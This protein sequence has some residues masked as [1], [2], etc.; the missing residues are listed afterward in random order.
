[1]LKWR[2]SLSVGEDVDF[3]WCI[4]VLLSL[5]A[6]RTLDH[7]TID[8]NAINDNNDSNGTKD[9][10]RRFDGRDWEPP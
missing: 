1:M 2:T 10:H 6:I 3:V 9:K 8:D 4:E 5:I 7:R